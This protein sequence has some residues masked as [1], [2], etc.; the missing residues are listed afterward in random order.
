MN[1][2]ADLILTVAGLL[3][4]FAIGL[5]LGR[6]RKDRAEKTVKSTL[7]FKCTHGPNNLLC[8][9][10]GCPDDPDWRGDGCK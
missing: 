10:Y 9:M 6:A 7:S 2:M 5:Q 4:L 1:D 3:L 8:K